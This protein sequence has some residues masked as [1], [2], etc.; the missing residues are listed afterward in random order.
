MKISKIASMLL[1]SSVT[2]VLVGCGN[3]DPSS[4]SPGTE[5]IS[6]KAADGYVLATKV[7]AGTDNILAGENNSTYNITLKRAVK[8]DENIT[9]YG[10][11][12]INGNGIKDV[13]DTKLGFP[14]LSTGQTSIVN[15]VTTLAVKMGNKDLLEKAKNFDPVADVAKAGDDNATKSLLILSRLVAEVAGKDSTKLADLAE[16]LKD[17][18]FTTSEENTTALTD[19]LKKS[20]KSAGLHTVVDSVAA[21]VDT[22]VEFVKTHGDKVDITKAVTALMDASEDTKVAL[23]TAA[24]KDDVNATD[25]NVSGIISEVKKSE[26]TIKSVVPTTLSINSITLGDIVSPINVEGNSS[27]GYTGDFGTITVDST[28]KKLSDFYNVKMDATTSKIKDINASLFDSTGKLVDNVSLTITIT[29]EDNTSKKVQ[30]K[31]TGVEVTLDHNSTETPLTVKMIP[32]TTK[33]AAYQTGLA[34][35]TYLKDDNDSVSANIASE[36]TN[37]DLEFDVNTILDNL[38]SSDDKLKTTISEL[39][40]YFAKNSS[41]SV[42]LKL[43]APKAEE[44]LS[45]TTLTGKVKVVNSKAP[46]VNHK[47]TITADTSVRTYDFGESVSIEV[48]VEDEDNDKLTCS[49][50]GVDWLSCSP[51]SVDGK[52]KFTI[53]GTAPSEKTEADATIKV[54]DVNGGCSSVNI[55]MDIRDKYAEAKKAVE[56]LSAVYDNTLMIKT[57]GETNSSAKDSDGDT[58]TITNIVNSAFVIGFDNA[59]A[60]HTGSSLT[61]YLAINGLED[62]KSVVKIDTDA[63]YKDVNFTLS[64]EGNDYNGTFDTTHDKYDSPL[65]LK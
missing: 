44:A 22:V 16:S 31:I 61:M 9:V 52:G 25:V 53:S 2:A 46:T 42:E 34:G 32:S 1:I 49:I 11:I 54:C 20:L 33:I 7:M 37:T 24:L 26:D 55:P 63:K 6:I 40:T 62:N 35:F 39:D 29:N 10:Y 58:V 56:R 41:Y 50:S 17:V 23:L 14:L 8:S 30:L 3:D 36:L 45:F 21:K 12:D 38:S 65:L 59:S 51:S 43:A 48:N 28:D 64:Y 47:P 15:P 57:A 27:A 19:E 5:S 4:A 18:N 60:T 13:N